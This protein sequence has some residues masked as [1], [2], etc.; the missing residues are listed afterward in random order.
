MQLAATKTGTVI[1]GGISASTDFTIEHN[2]KMFRLLSDTLYQNKKG[3]MVREISCNAYDAHVAAGKPDVPFTIH[4]PTDIEPWFSVIDQGVGL[5]DEEIRTIFTCFGKS[6]KSESNSMIGAFGFG[7]KTPFAYTNAFTVISVKDGVRNSYA[8]IIGEDGLPVINLMGSEDTTDENGVTI[9]VAVETYDFEDF[10][11]EVASQLRYFKVKPIIKGHPVTFEDPMA[12]VFESVNDNTHFRHYGSIEVVQGGVAYPVDVAQLKKA[13]TNRKPEL[14]TFITGAVHFYHPIMFFDI[15]SIAVTP[16]R[17]SISYDNATIRNILDRLEVV[18]AALMEKVHSQMDAALSIWEKTKVLR[19][20]VDLF[21][22]LFNL[23]DNRWGIIAQNNDAYIPV[24][25]S[26]QFEIVNTGNAKV[27]HYVSH[28]IP[29]R[30]N[31]GNFRLT[32]NQERVSRII[33]TDNSVIVIDDGCGYSLSRIRRYVEESRNQVYFLTATKAEL[34]KRYN[35]YNAKDELI[36]TREQYHNFVQGEVDPVVLAEML[37]AVDGAEVI[38]LSSLEKQER[39]YIVKNDDGTETIRQKYT[40]AKAYKFDG[41]WGG[42]YGNE[43]LSTFKKYDKT[44]T[45]PKKMPEEVAY[46][47]VN[48]RT[49]TTGIGYAD[50]SILRQ[51]ISSGDFTLPIYAIRQKDVA[52]VATNPKWVPLAKAIADTKDKVM[53]KYKSVHVR[54]AAAWGGTH[55]ETIIN[56][57]VSNFLAANMHR[58]ADPSFRRLLA[59]KQRHQRRKHHDANALCNLLYAEQMTAIGERIRLK[60]GAIQTKIKARYPLLFAMNVSH[61]HTMTV[62]MLEDLLDMINN[63]YAKLLAS[64]EVS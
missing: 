60:D 14:E 9:S 63:R 36:D 41:T 49:I 28:Y 29:A 58:V 2:G 39:V 4:T 59:R 55:I 22:K 38:F 61:Y 18:H 5:S 37:Q 47:L 35:I 46:V 45:A 43:S 1:Q 8:A 3:S 23:K 57:V 50:V 6:T 33:P 56:G 48:N 27:R 25:E 15:G 62:D 42:K 64:G 11:G 30:N 20:N 51:A 52:K 7:S 21:S 40:P 24:P 32:C 53:Q 34:E 13:L 10:Y 54:V 17:E 16:S 19:S 44:F 26:A 31:V 12:S